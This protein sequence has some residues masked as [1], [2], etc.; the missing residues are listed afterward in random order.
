VR[1]SAIADAAA[2][3]W[4]EATGSESGE[5]GE[6]GPRAAPAVPLTVRPCAIA[7]AAALRWL[8]RHGEP[9]PW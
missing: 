9:E 4:E 8:E 5:M 6:P 3:R 1:R 7:Q 2:L